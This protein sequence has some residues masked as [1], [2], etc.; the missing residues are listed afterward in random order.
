MAS[1]GE[2]QKTRRLNVMISDDLLRCLAETA[3]RRG[4]SVSA[5]VR[6]AVER[7]YR[8]SQDEDL[9]RIAEALAPLYMTDKELTAFHSLD[10]EAFL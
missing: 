6:Q 1:I 4:V 3:Q 9:A 10:G 7:E 5:V 8:L 2:G